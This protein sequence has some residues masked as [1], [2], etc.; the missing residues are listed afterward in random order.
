[1]NQVKKSENKLIYWWKRYFTK[2]SN[3][4]KKQGS[5]ENEIKDTMKYFAERQIESI[6]Q[7]KPD[8]TKKVDDQLNDYQ[9]EYIEY[10]KKVIET[11]EI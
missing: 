1:M 9:K 3:G 8:K 11:G 5:N 7:A 4:M 2:Y 6:E 10:L